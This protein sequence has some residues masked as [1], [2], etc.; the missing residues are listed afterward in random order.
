MLNSSWWFKLLVFRTV[1][2]ILVRL[3]FIFFK[4]FSFKIFCFLWIIFIFLFRFLLIVLKLCYFLTFLNF[5]LSLWWYLYFFFLCLIHLRL[6]WGGF[7]GHLSRLLILSRWYTFLT[8]FRHSTIQLNTLP[9]TGWRL[10]LNDRFL[11][12][13]YHIHWWSETFL[14]RSIV[15][16]WW[17]W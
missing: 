9:S 5:F 2:I 1:L 8:L 10:Q 17:S 4:S 15:S 16:S 13:R 3:I 14:R 7:K 6:R 11:I 12:A